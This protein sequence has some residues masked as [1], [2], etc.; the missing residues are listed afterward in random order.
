MKIEE[1]TQYDS[2]IEEKG[3]ESE[4]PMIRELLKQK[5]RYSNYLHLFHL[6]DK[7]SFAEDGIVRP[8]IIHT[9]KH[10]G[11]KGN[12]SLTY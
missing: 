4:L 10:R 12:G 2:E 9:Y 1:G 11:R 3:D 8:P 6:E 5:K 7:V